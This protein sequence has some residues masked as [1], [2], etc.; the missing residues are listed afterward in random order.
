[1]ITIRYILILFLAAPFHVISQDTTFSSPV[2]YNGFLLDIERNQD[3]YFPIIN[4]DFLR[5]NTTNQNKKLVD[6]IRT[7]LIYSVGQRGFECFSIE[8]EQRVSDSSNFYLGYDKFNFI[9]DIS[10][11]AFASGAF[12]GGLDLGKGS[13]NVELDF[14]SRRNEK[15][16]NGGALDDSLLTIGSARSLV[17]VSNNEGS[18]SGNLYNFNGQV[19]YKV[20]SNTALYV[21][22]EGKRFDYSF[23]DSDLTDSLYSAQSVIIDSNSTNDFYREGYE[24]YSI[25][26][27]HSFKNSQVSVAG[28]FMNSYYRNNGFKAN[29]SPSVQVSHISKNKL[30]HISSEALIAFNDQVNYSL[31][32]SIQYLLANGSDVIAELFLTEL[33]AVSFSDMYQGNHVNW[34]MNPSSNRSIGIN[35]SYN[36]TARNLDLVASFCSHN[37]VPIIEDSVVSR[38][39]VEYLQINGRKRIEFREWQIDGVY[40]PTLNL[41]NNKFFFP[42]HSGR[43]TIGRNLSFFKGKLRTFIHVAGIGHSAYDRPAINAFV[44]VLERSINKTDA[45]VYFNAGIRAKIGDLL[46]GFQYWNVGSGLTFDYAMYT[47]HVVDP[48]RFFSLSFGLEFND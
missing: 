14:Q 22:G 15:G 13:W 41:S 23:S 47:N 32:S 36:D 40:T 16:V 24:V 4:Q 30:V 31:Q 12:R 8:H 35:L 6:T 2:H 25:G 7:E 46:F 17:P 29:Y 44:P 27:A 38:N 26:A 20:F 45:N 3:L 48:G 43:V 28:G 21:R 39:K 18:K 42:L 33:H 19:S 10:N 11:S 9:D 5:V 1:M 37:Q 34:S